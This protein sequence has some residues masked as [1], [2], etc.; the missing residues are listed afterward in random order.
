MR[1]F[2]QFQKQMQKAH[3]CEKCHNK[4]ISIMMDELGKRRCSYCNEI[5]NYPEPTVEEM[6]AW[7]NKS[8]NEK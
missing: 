6:K 7:I 3:D 5:V 4:I 2:K 1:T 8:K